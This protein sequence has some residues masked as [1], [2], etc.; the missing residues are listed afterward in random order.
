MSKKKGKLFDKI[1]AISSRVFDPVIEIPV[2]LSAAVLIAVNNGMRWRFLALLL[3]VDAVLPAGYLAWGL[4]SGKLSDWDITDRK[5]RMSIY[6]FAVLTHLFGV[7]LALFIGKYV[8]FRILLVWWSMAVVFFVVTLFWK[9]SVHAGVNAALVVFVNHFYGWDRYWWLIG[10]LILV[11]WARVRSN[12]HTWV[13]VL[14][15]AGLALLWTGLGLQV[16]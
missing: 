11:M 5:E 3:L 4:K 12:K 9:I 16:I 1:A 2:L 15:G 10:G 13:Q 7:L 8:L 6:L 14:V